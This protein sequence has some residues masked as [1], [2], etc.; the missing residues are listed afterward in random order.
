MKTKKTIHQYKPYD[1]Y[2]LSGAASLASVKSIMQSQISS[3]VSTRDAI[4]S[5]H[6]ELSVNFFALYTWIY[7]EVINNKNGLYSNRVIFTGV[8]KNANL[9]NKAS[10]TFASLGIPTLYLNSCHAT[11]G[12]L[13]LIGPDDIVIHISMSGTTKETLD[14]AISIKNLASARK[15]SIKQVLLTGTPHKTSLFDLVLCCPNIKEAHYHVK[16]PTSSTSVFIFVLDTLG[17][18]ISETMG[19]TKDDFYVFHPGGTLGQM[20]KDN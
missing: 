8:G 9:A 4:I 15:T 2:E 1:T 20:Y 13:G 5:P 6:T 12:D 7:Q 11:H 16:A 19:I 17:V 14:A 18:L 3:I 10:E